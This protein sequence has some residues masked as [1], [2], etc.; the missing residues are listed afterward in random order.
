MNLQPQPSFDGSPVRGSHAPSL[1]R[2]RSL[3]S[4]IRAASIVIGL[5]VAAPAL[6][7]AS[8]PML[9]GTPAASHL[10]TMKAQVEDKARVA[11]RSVARQRL[12]AVD[13]RYLDPQSPE[14]ATE[15]GVELFDG[16]I[17]TIEL[18]QIDRR[19]AQ[20]YTWYG[21]VKGYAESQVVLTVVD[22]QI[23][24][25]ILMLDSAKRGGA[26]YQIHSAADGSQVLREINQDAFPPD[27]PSGAAGT[28]IPP[29]QLKSTSSNSWT[30]SGSGT[31][32]SSTTAQAAADSAAYIDVMVVYG[33][34]TAAAAGTAIAAQIQ[35]AIDT[36]NAAYANSGVTTRLRLVHYEQVSYAE[37]GDFNTDLNR[38][39]TAGDG[40][41][42]NVAT[43]RNTYGADLVSLFVENPQYCGIA[44]IGP[45]ANYAYS[46]VNRG[47]ASGNYSFAHE[48]AH[49]FGALHDPYV[50]PG[51][52]PYA[53]GHGLTDPAEGWRTVMA[54]NDACM[55]AGT[56]C[57]RIPFFSNPNLTYGSPANPLGTTSTSDNARVLNDNALTVANFRSS[58]VASACTYA[59]SPS[60]AS[61]GAGGASASFAVTSGSGCAWHATT[62]ASWLS[63]GSGS[64][65][66]GSGSLYYVASANPGAARSGTIAVGGKAF[67]VS[68]ASGCT[69]ALSPT[70]ATIAA[71]GATS[72]VSVTSG[73]GCA[74]TAT[75]SAGWL[76]VSTRSGTGAGSV[77]YS[78]ASNAGSTRSA[79][80]AI[81]GA[82]F[83]VT[84]NGGTTTVSSSGVP[85]LS[86]K[87]I[88]FGYV[89]VGV[90]S[91]PR[92]VK[93][94]NS[95][96]GALS[97]GALTQAGVNP[98]DFL[99]SGTCAVGTSL[100]AGK[101]CTVT[102]TFRPTAK[103]S[104]TASLALATSGGT[105]ALG[106]N[107]MGQ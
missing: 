100:A 45:N 68:Q 13:F 102:Y 87:A 8:L 84:Q 12:V 27:H 42:D 14:A 23:D 25:S 105:V 21:Q 59:L 49:N 93:L 2:G 28:P 50:D 101:S 6:A 56:S 16:Q 106:L 55:A 88:S 46:V 70:S 76:T 64:A 43:L 77:T 32:T 78:V 92:T 54:Y 20:S 103:G 57:V 66:S 69:Y 85:T 29:A 33:N 11:D 34:Q 75:S 81:G 62:S 91:W 30:T 36:T 26:V 35:Q 5:L 90:K 83:L 19:G 3:L 67:T 7:A 65:T 96:S 39:T 38:L 17:A 98:G 18:Q 47:C 10:P 22:G 61:V 73:A 1:R 74:W 48:L 51:T 41:M 44:W 79:N 71:S 97:I 24:G 82:T 58:V 72:S 40:Y 9:L 99:R 89:R 60:S 15:L 104:R 94:T 37:S 31:T 80:L 86:A 4:G 95:G 52:S 63:I 53:Y 107:G